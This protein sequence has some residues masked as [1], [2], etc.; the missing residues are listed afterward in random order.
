MVFVAFLAP[1]GVYFVV[2]GLLHRRSRPLVASGAWDAVGLLFGL[3]G[4]LLAGGPAILT[5]RND[6]WRAWWLLA[7]TEAPRALH[8]GYLDAHL[9]W[10]LAASLAYYALVAGWATWLVWRARATTSIYAT[11]RVDVALALDEACRDL[12]LSPQRSGNLYVFGSA[13]G[14]ATLDLEPF[15]ALG[16]VSL[17]WEPPDSPMRAPVESALEEK[18]AEVG[19]P[20]SDVGLYL[21]WAGLACLGSAVAIV[22]LFLQRPHM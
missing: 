12:Q 2:V 16:H 19:S 20:D 14:H 15:D 6:R 21:A 17:R 5:A 18:L 8:D 9:P 11:A 4:F 1:L 3:S 7:N 22:F 10:W 13:E